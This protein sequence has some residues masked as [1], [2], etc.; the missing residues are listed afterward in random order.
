MMKYSK[1][2]MREHNTFSGG[3]SGAKVPIKRGPAAGKTGQSNMSGFSKAFRGGRG[4]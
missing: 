3:R 2:K 1:A 4:R